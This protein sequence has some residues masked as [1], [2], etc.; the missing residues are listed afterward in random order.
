MC[1]IAGF[2]GPRNDKALNGMLAVMVN[3]GPDDGGIHVTPCVSLGHSRLSI[4]DLSRSARQPMTDVTGRVH[5]TFNGEIY[6]FQTLRRMLAPR[7]A[8][9]SS[10]DSESIIAAYLAF[11]REQFLEH[12]DG[13][14]AFALWDD[15]DGSLFLARDR[16][17][18]KPLYWCEIPGGIAFA[19][20]LRSLIRHPEVSI[21]PNLEALPEYLL[22]RSVHNPGTALKGVHKLPPGHCL[23][24]KDGCVRESRYWEPDF[25][26]GDMNAPQAARSLRCHLENACATHMVADVPVA[27][28]LSGGLD[29][30]ILATLASKVT[31]RLQTFSIGFSGRLDNEFAFA[32]KLASELGTRHRELTVTPGHIKML[33]RVVY[34]NDEPVAGPSSIAYA[35]ALAE[36]KKYCKVILFGHG[37]DELL[38]GYEQLK[39]MRLTKLLRSIP[40]VPDTLAILARGA[41]AFFPDDDAFARLYQFVQASDLAE[42]YLLLV[43]VASPSEARK[44]LLGCVEPAI[45][46]ALQTA[47]AEESDPETAILR[48]EQGGWLPD[49]IL[50]RVDRMTMAHSIEGRVPYLD[51]NVVECANALP[52]RYKLKRG[53]EKYILRKAFSDIL[54]PEIFK[55]RKK[56]FNTPIHTFF[57]VDYERLVQRLFSSDHQLTRHIFDK[58]KLMHLL[59]F[60]QTVSYR[61]LLRGN[62]LAA[63]Y[64]SRQIW[65]IVVYMLWFMTVV[66]RQDPEEVGEQWI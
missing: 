60:R 24:V 19:S 3:R 35:L 58:R 61:W 33:P 29:S 32:S 37:A 22:L 16:L 41:S 46:S 34:D 8:F 21:R 51:R 63:Q 59:E 52:N 15:L 18:I 7:Y 27:V 5:L 54:P 11:G 20:E 23:L 38:A 30:S 14:F 55:R 2:T 4:I 56:R 47:F 28:F 13:M 12:L 10:S 62:T 44:S 1:G 43:S 66:E 65:S 17:G 39:L 42:A 57:G 36:A 48:F 53:V 50:H 40:L 64:F 31:D 9:S 45:P 49:D 6:N 25:T 26:P